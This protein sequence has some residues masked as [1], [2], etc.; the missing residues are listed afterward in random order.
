MDDKKSAAVE[1]SVVSVVAA[2][3]AA[4][5]GLAGSTAAAGST[6]GVGW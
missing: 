4:G 2:E 5:E 3:E 6:V 1:F